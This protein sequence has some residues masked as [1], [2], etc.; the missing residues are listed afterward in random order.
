MN[1]LIR[2]NMKRIA[3]FFLILSVVL[4]QVFG[5]ATA[6]RNSVPYHG[7]RLENNQKGFSITS[8]SKNANRI[9]VSFSS[10]VNPQSI[11]KSNILINGKAI[12]SSP[13]NAQIRF[14]RSGRS[15]EIELECQAPSGN[16]SING[17]KSFNGENLSPN[18]AKL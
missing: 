2:K 8:V 9:T 13:Y 1:V 4:T 16:I 3:S 14:D 6:Q 12:S 10:P 18:T 15:M 17:V 11:S 7:M 5:Q